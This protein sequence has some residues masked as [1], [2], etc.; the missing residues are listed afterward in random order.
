MSQLTRR[1]RRERTNA[2]SNPRQVTVST[3]STVPLQYGKSHILVSG[4]GSPGTNTTPGT[5]V[6]NPPT[7]GNI[8]GYNPDSPGNVIGYNPVTPGNANYNPSTPGNIV[9]Y[10]PSTPGPARPTSWAYGT[11]TW[12]NGL[13]YYQYFSVPGGSAPWS[14]SS[15]QGNFYAVVDPEIIIYYA[16]NTPGNANYN[17]PS[18]ST[19]ANYNPSSGGNPVYNPVIPGNANYNLPAPG[20][21][22]YNPPTPGN[23]ASYNPDQP[24]NLAGYN[25]NVPGNYVSTNPSSGHNVANYN[26]ST[27]GNPTYNPTTPAQYVSPTVTD[28]VTIYAVYANGSPAPGIVDSYQVVYP[29]GNVPYPEYYQFYTENPNQKTWFDHY[30]VWAAGYTNPAIPGNFAGYNPM[31]PGNANYNPTIPGNANYNPVKPGNAYYNQ[32]IP[33]NANYNP[34]VPGTAVY[35]PATPG[36][37][38][39]P[40]T[41]VGVVFPGAPAGVPG[42]YV[43]AQIVSL[44]STQTQVNVNVGPGGSVVIK[45][46]F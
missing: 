33:G 14:S 4:N 40:F 42:N 16:P 38:S 17:P 21:A 19:I 44:P 24:G 11:F 39:A 18:P 45:Q 28:H 6:Y 9:G 1:L 36:Q 20:N 31:T 13:Q 8:S 23:V 43:A 25:P 32:T 29:A 41:A 30:Q 37:P 2:L 3:P 22:V 12:P 26:P 46:Q 5:A 34:Y 7:P 10:N 27:P 35:N 15:S